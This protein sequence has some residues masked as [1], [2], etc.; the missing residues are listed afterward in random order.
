MPTKS[1]KL[2]KRRSGHCFSCGEANGGRSDA[3][4]SN[5]TLFE[6][7]L[8]RI[9]SHFPRSRSVIQISSKGAYFVL[10]DTWVS[11]SRSAPRRTAQ[12]KQQVYIS[13][14]I[15]TLG[16]VLSAATLFAVSG[17]HSLHRTSFVA[18]CTR[19]SRYSTTLILTLERTRL[20]TMPFGVFGTHI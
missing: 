4:L 2:R 12:L 17:N 20:G 9:R 6:A 3:P 5:L 19:R 10:T 16:I 14:S 11:R 1:R 7:P 13:G 15:A 8:P 18:I